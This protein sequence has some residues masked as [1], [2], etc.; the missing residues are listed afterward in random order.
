MA[1]RDS[2]SINGNSYRIADQS[3]IKA[4]R[5]TYIET[6]RPSQPFETTPQVVSWAPWGPLGNSRQRWGG[7]LTTDYADNLDTRNEYLLTSTAKVTS[8][9]SQITGI[10]NTYA[11]PIADIQK[12]NWSEGAGNANADAFDE[13]DEGINSGTPDDATTYWETSTADAEIIM[14][15]TSLT[16]PDNPQAS[17]M[18]FR[19]N[20]TA[21]ITSVKATLY[22]TTTAI[23]SQAVTPITG[24]WVTLSAFIAESIMRQIADWTNIRLGFEFTAGTGTLQLSTVE[25]DVVENTPIRTLNEDRGQ[26]FG[27]AGSISVQYN[28]NAGGDIIRDSIVNHQSD[29]T[30]EVSWQGSAFVALGSADVV[31]QRTAVG[32]GG[33]TAYGDVANV[34][35]THFAVGPERVWL[36]DAGLT[37]AADKNKLKFAVDDLTSA[38]LS[39]AFQVAD[40]GEEV[41]G[42]IANG[43]YV[44]SAFETGVNSFTSSGRPVRM[45]EAIDQ[46]RS[47]DNGRSGDTLWGWSYHA[48]KLGLFAIDV[49]GPVVNP[50]GPGEGLPGQGFEGPP[51]GY[52]TAVKAFKDSLWVAYLNP[53]GDSYLF[54]GTFGPQTAATGRPEWFNFRKLSSVQCRAIGSTAARSRPTIAWGEDEDIAYADLSFRGRE[55]ADSSYLFDTGG[56]QWFGTTLMMPIGVRGNV[57]WAKLFTEN[58]VDAT[59]TWQVH[60]DVDDADSYI[61]IGSAITA[62]GAQT[63]RP[64]SGGAPLATVAFTSLKP[65]LTQVAASETAPPQIRGE[66]AI[67]IDARPE[68]VREVDVLLDLEQQSDLADLQALVTDGTVTPTALRLPTQTEVNTNLYGYVASAQWYDRTDPTDNVALVKLIEWEVS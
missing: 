36:A 9:D 25:L 3:R 47:S 51:D 31:Q 32:T 2:L 23:H 61:A 24:S 59:D 66:L 68:F 45:L 49:T 15:L 20:A 6:Q 10:T 60:V 55:I 50:V 48:T 4:S 17:Q 64:V 27:S 18:R 34:D 19:Y 44:L 28:P 46:F 54:R 13:L 65:R 21:G 11:V 40:P 7:P 26:L 38:N 52:P 5:R 1:G 67:G 14:R 37:T 42:L 58:C 22:T 30:D 41:T 35:A 43:P 56:G 29:I 8:V 39:N 12:T 57:R 16:A 63:V 62:N 33:V 53:D